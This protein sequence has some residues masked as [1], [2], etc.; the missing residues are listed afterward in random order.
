MFKMYLYLGTGWYMPY[1][2][3]DTLVTRAAVK[4]KTIVSAV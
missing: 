4:N 2:V 1:A 3:R